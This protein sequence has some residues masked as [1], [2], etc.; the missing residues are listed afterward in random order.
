MKNSIFYLLTLALFLFTSCNKNSSKPDMSSIVGTYDGSIRYSSNNNNASAT[1]EVTELNEYAVNVHCYSTNFD[2]TFTMDIYQEGN[3]V[4][5]NNGSHKNTQMDKMHKH[6]T[7]E[8]HHGSFD[9]N[10]KAFS[11][12]FDESM[13]TSNFFGIKK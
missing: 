9:V 4:Y 5:C 12:S 7:N 3:T 2:T 11:Y 1:A 8:N 10:G 6:C 13:D